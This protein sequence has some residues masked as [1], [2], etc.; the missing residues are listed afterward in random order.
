MPSSCLDVLEK[1]IQTVIEINPSS[2]LDFGVGFGKYGHLCREYLEL[3]NGRYKKEDWQ[4]RID[5]IEVFSSYIQDHQKAIY[6]AIHIWDLNNLFDIPTSVLWHTYDLYLMMDVLE[7]LYNWEKIFDVI[8]KNSAIIAATPF[9][10]YPQGAVFGNEYERHVQAFVLEDLQ[11][12]FDEVEHI[13][14][15]IWCYRRRK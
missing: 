8:P 5:G 3:I 11:P 12:Y 9:G 6:N 13:K 15:T 10:D 7:H 2:I 14:N 4:V 1:T